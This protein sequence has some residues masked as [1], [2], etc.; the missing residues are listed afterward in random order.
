MS[1]RPPLLPLLTCLTMLIQW[2]TLYQLIPDSIMFP[3][4]QDT[5]LCLQD[6]IPSLQDSIFLK[7]TPP[8]HQDSIPCFQ[9]TSLSL[10]DTIL[11]HDQDALLILHLFTILQEILLATLYQLLNLVVPIR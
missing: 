2:E 11:C 1:L 6:S 10:Q 7:K 9:D 5:I 8:L 3:L 4:L